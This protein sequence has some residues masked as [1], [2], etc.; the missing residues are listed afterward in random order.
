MGKGGGRLYDGALIAVAFGVASGD[1]EPLVAIEFAEQGM[2][3]E[4]VAQL[5]GIGR[6]VANSIVRWRGASNSFRRLESGQ[7][8]VGRRGSGAMIGW[9]TRPKFAK[10][11][12]SVMAGF[13]AGSGVFWSVRVRPA[14]MCCSTIVMCSRFSATDQRLT[15]GRY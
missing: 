8:E 12:S 15:P 11:C 1:D 4:I 13:L 2:R 3:H 7:R 6:G 9:T 5:L 14:R 10:S